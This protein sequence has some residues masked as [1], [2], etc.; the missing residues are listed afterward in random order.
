MAPERD[1]AITVLTN[2][3]P[4]G[5]ALRGQLVRWALEAYLGVVE[6]EPEPASLSEDE[7]AAYTGSFETL[8]AFLHI[9]V[10]ADRLLVVAEL[11][12]EAIAQ[13]V[14]AGEDPPDAPPPF[15]LVM[16]A[17]GAD[18]YL[19]V[20]GP[21]QGMQGYFVRDPSGAVEAVHVGRLATRVATAARA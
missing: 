11:K 13:E 7:L 19:V 9:S 4:N 16:V 15:H 20:D 17:T 3:G 2:C 14:A 8:A 10:E 18:R 6:R 12:P 1:F 21:Y 5:Q